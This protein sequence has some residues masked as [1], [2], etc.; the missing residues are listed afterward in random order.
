MN[1]ALRIAVVLV[2]GLTAAVA[3]IS[4]PVPKEREKPKWPDTEEATPT[5]D[6]ER[7]EFKFNSSGNLKQIGVAI[8]NHASAEQHRIPHNIIDK[9]GKPLLSWRVAVLP[10][11]EGGEKLYHEF[12][13]DEPWDSPNNIKLI[14]KMPQVFVSPR[15]KVRKG[16]TVYQCFDGP[17]AVL[18]SNYNIGNI[19]DGTSNTLWCVEATAAV[20][21]T[22]PA[23]IPFDPKK[24]LPKFGKAYG[25]EP[26]GLLMDGSTR[27]LDLKTIKPDTLKHAIQADDGEVLGED[28]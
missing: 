2:A 16:Y 9:D 26:L 28:W 24:D 5:T 21:W 12:K 10:Y 20:P 18:T 17:G 14:E 3:A 23:D 1:A 4:A 22:K 13:F 27:Y 7:A 19:P 6:A 11:L 25:D 15:A 8:H